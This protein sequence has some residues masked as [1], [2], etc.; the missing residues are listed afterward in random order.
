MPN[1]T[2]ADVARFTI[3]LFATGIIGWLAWVVLLPLNA[4]SIGAGTIAALL[5]LS[6]TLGRRWRVAITLTTTLFSMALANLAMPL[7]TAKDS[8]FYFV[9]CGGVRADCLTPIPV[10]TPLGH[11]SV[12]AINDPIRMSVWT[13]ISRVNGRVR[14]IGS[15]QEDRDHVLLFSSAESELI[16]I[17]RNDD[18]ASP[19]IVLNLDVPI[20][21]SSFTHSLNRSP[22][23]EFRAGFS[24]LWDWPA[25]YWMTAQD[26]PGMFSVRAEAHRLR[27]A[28]AEAAA[29]DLELRALLNGRLFDVLQLIEESR[30][31]S[32]ISFLRHATL[33]LNLCRTMMRDNLLDI[34]CPLLLRRYG[35]GALAQQVANAPGDPASVAF[36]WSALQTLQGADLMIAGGETPQQNWAEGLF[37]G[38]FTNLFERQGWF[39]HASLRGNYV[40]GAPQDVG[41]QILAGRQLASRRRQTEN[42][43][44]G[45]NWQQ[46]LERRIREAPSERVRVEL[47]ALRRDQISRLMIEG[48]PVDEERDVDADLLSFAA[49]PSPNQLFGL[50]AARSSTAE[51]S[52]RYDD[53]LAEF[54]A[55]PLV[56]AIFA[57]RRERERSRVVFARRLA[58]SPTMGT[59]I[60]QIIMQQRQLGCS[61]E[62]ERYLRALPI[63][64]QEGSMRLP[65]NSSGHLSWWSCD[66]RRLMLLD[67]MIAFQAMGAARDGERWG[68]QLREP[69]WQR[70]GPQGQ[71]EDRITGLLVADLV[72]F[73]MDDQR[74]EASER[75]IELMVGGK[76]AWLEIAEN[77]ISNH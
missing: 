45:I 71:G 34:E 24:V 35:I 26:A 39:A 52:I 8:G 47:R 53:V 51:I 27:G 50:I 33:E 4:F 38:D 14:R 70:Y 18:G 43:A 40:E 77:H 75:R 46:R 66:A 23:A 17:F 54:D 59:M 48:I 72:F 11:S 1:L 69:L 5:A 16:G 31:Q 32:G 28:W 10:R 7:F 55:S 67:S 2:F 9:D 12:F 58:S 36:L 21:D 56:T 20:F 30:N 49:R 13:A 63:L 22:H 65:P 44:R 62:T 74:H 41:A 57:R 60:E 25:L 15:T 3:A 76:P 29:S 64:A 6:A 73:A 42:D 61:V 19:T 37:R 68:D